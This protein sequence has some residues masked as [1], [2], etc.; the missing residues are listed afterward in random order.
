MNIFKLEIHN[1]KKSILIWTTILSVIIFLLLAFFP[2]MQSEGMQQIAN[3]K[4]ESISPGVLAILGFEQIP[5][6]TVVTNYFGY[7][8]Q[9]IN[10]AVAMFVMLKGTNTLIREETEGT[11][12][13]LYVKP[14]SRI[15][16][17]VGKL[18]ANIVG[19]LVMLAIIFAVTVGS[20]LAYTDYSLSE[21]VHEISILL[22][23]TLFV[24][25]VFLLFGFFLSA[26]LPSSR[27]SASVSLGVVFGTFLIGIISVLV[28]KLDFLIY[29][30]PLD[31]IKTNKLMGD[32]LG[33]G[34][35]ILGLGIMVC[36]IVAT[37]IIY[38]KKDFR[39]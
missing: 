38:Q 32:G 34:E 21:A 23:G 14:V 28:Q 6:F 39:V 24:G 17:L 12:E 8:L 18:L 27:Q 9:Y 30:S 13:Y 1:L 29:L 22:G 26:L 35:L 2:S 11:I 31:W 3:A 4:L 5:D 15:N 19:Y 37:L 36:S 16:I 7:V 10:L 25:I 20:Y 33:T